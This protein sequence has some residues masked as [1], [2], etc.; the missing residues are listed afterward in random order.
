[1]KVVIAA[2]E[3]LRALKRVRGAVERRNTIPILANVVLEA[4]GDKLS[5]RAT[6][7]D[8]E[9]S[10]SVPA[11]VETKGIT[12]VGAEMLFQFIS[13][14]ARDSEVVIEQVKDRAQIAVKAGRSRCTLNTLPAEDF[15]DLSVGELTHSFE[16]P[17]TGLSRLFSRAQFAISTEETRYYLNGIYLHPI[18]KQLRAVAT[19]G[20]R[21]ALVD[22]AIPVGAE[23]MPGVIV[24]R[25]AIT[26][27]LKLVE[28]G[29][30]VAIQLSQ[31]KIRFDFGG[32]VM[33]TKLID[34]KFPDYGR[35]IPDGNHKIAV[36]DRLELDAA[37]DRVATVLDEG[38]AAKF[39][40][41][42][43]KLVLSATGADI[44]SASEDIDVGYDAA[45]NGDVEVGF[46]AK[47]IHSIIGNIGSEKIRIELADP[48][49][50]AVFK[51]EG[52]PGA[53]FVCMPMRV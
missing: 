53:L 25:K 20:H 13:K 48:G 22:F 45:E 3:I 10:L 21:L 26:E 31:T 15:P 30:T 37:V 46:N 28:G 8:L 49:A 5:L 50:P 4:V 39:S 38:R 35:V 1:M 51:G 11:K 29:E 12:T 36:C 18:D 16:I 2:S 24:P 32:T 42:A 34:G 43:D 17:D 23:D 33:V 27:S 44:G 47:Y 9:I 19:D 14:L 52:E 41:S 7:L 6:D 40:F